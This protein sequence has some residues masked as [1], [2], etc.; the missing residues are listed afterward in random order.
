MGGNC[1]RL[2]PVLAMGL[3]GCLEQEPKYQCALGSCYDAMGKYVD[4]DKVDPETPEEI[5]SYTH[6]CRMMPKGA[7]K[8][9]K[10]VIF[11]MHIEDLGGNF[12]YAASEGAS[13]A[14][15]AFQRHVEQDGLKYTSDSSPGM[16][17]DILRI[18]SDGAAV[19]E[20]HWVDLN[21]KTSP[22]QRRVTSETLV[23]TCTFGGKS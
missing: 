20:R 4:P 22:P 17:A 23:G 8:G 16:R 7:A 19:L 6:Y 21:S 10:E 3:A 2:L 14:M 1:A 15:Q 5:A 11:R 9:T 12:A 13:D 18:R